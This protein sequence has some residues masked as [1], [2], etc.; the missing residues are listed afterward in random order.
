MTGDFGRL[1]ESTV[2]ILG[3]AVLSPGAAAMGVMVWNAVVVPQG[4]RRPVAL[5]LWLQA[6]IYTT[7]LVNSLDPLIIHLS[8]DLLLINA[9]LVCAQALIGAMVIFQMFRLRK[10]LTSMLTILVAFLW[11]KVLH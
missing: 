4:L 8:F 11:V 3:Y 2:L 10:L 7:L 5:F 6:A 1:I 9:A